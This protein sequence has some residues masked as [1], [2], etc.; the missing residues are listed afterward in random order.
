MG[1]INAV[2][3]NSMTDFELLMLYK[4]DDNGEALM[5]LFS[6][7]QPLIQNRI[8]HFNFFGNDLEDLCQ[9]CMIGLYSAIMSYEPS[10]ASFSTFARLC[11]DRMLISELRRRNRANVIPDDALVRFDG[12]QEMFLAEAGVDPQIIFERLDSFE[13]LKDKVKGMLS[14]MEYTVLFYAVS[15]M[16][17][18]EI[19]DKLS[20]SLKSVDNAIQRIRK[21]LSDI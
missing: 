9:E 19:A 10:K 3:L 17:Y 12:E 16:S 7:Y 13:N 14:K 6:R 18:K 4:A 5:L 20:V 2:E 11:I 8:R 21:K 15:G 1:S